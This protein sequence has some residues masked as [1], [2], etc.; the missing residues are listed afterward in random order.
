M[1]FWTDLNNSNHLSKEEAQKQGSFY[2]PR[3][4]AIQMAKKLKWKP[5]K[6]VLDPCC[7]RGA[8][9]Q[10]CLEVYPQLTNNLLFGIDIDPIAIQFCIDH[11]PNGNFRVGNCL[12]DDFNS[13]HFWK[14]RD[15]PTQSYKEYCEKHPK[16]FKFGV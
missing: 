2:T 7:G 10:S 14:K 8:L 16:P 6:K 13:E 9:F 15:Y 12:E 1:D 4:L 5:T 3:E 11:F